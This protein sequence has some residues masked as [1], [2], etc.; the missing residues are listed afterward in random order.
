MRRVEEN[1]S[2]GPYVLVRSL[3]RGGFARVFQ[4]ASEVGHVALKVLDPLSGDIAV[5]RD[6]LR[7][8]LAAA[9]RVDSS[10]V[11][12]PFEW[13]LDGDP[14]WIAYAWVPGTTLADVVAKAPARSLLTS[15]LLT[16]FTDVA[17]A[18]EAIHAVG[19]VHR[20]IKP[21]NI[22]VT[23][24]SE[25]VVVDLGVAVIGEQSEYTAGAWGTDGYRPPEQQ[26]GAPLDGRADVWSF[27]V[28]LIE[29]ATGRRPFG[30]PHERDYEQRI[31]ERP[32]VVGLPTALLDLSLACT[33][34]RAA[35]RPTSEALVASL[36]AINS[37]WQM[38][39]PVL[40]KAGRYDDDESAIAPVVTRLELLPPRSRV[41]ARGGVVLDVPVVPTPVGGTDTVVTEA[42]VRPALGQ[43]ALAGDYAELFDART[44]TKVLPQLRTGVEQL[45]ELPTRCPSCGGPLRWQESGPRSDRGLFCLADLDCPAQAGLRLRD[46]LRGVHKPMK[47]QEDAQLLEEVARR[48]AVRTIADLARLGDRDLRVLELEPEQRERVRAMR[49]A[50]L[51]VPAVDLLVGL[52]GMGHLHWS[53]RSRLREQG[54]DLAAVSRGGP[55]PE[56]MGQVS[57]QVGEWMQDE[58]NAQVLRDTVRARKS[59]RGRL[60]SGRD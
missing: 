16:I 6:L 60:P 40:D 3:G 20:D 56:D 2:V 22:M 7:R 4:A 55:L 32:A 15:P 14:P 46:A 19:I 8:E 31:A 53:G 28:C 11:A 59:Y 30:H 27:G 1:D 43:A 52:I 37:T 5:A 17:V 10:R 21:T 45:H 41:T 50:V 39:R 12:R 44:I 42:F 13:D 26:A 38:V 23:P 34:P 49:E 35:D 54:L 25:A 9:Q 57:R 33:S 18:L 58:M 47:W 36:R 48:L 29:A 24:R 51:T